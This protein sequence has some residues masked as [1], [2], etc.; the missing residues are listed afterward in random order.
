MKGSKSGRYTK[1]ESYVNGAAK[2]DLNFIKEK[3]II[4]LNSKK[5]KELLE[6]LENDSKFLQSLK[7]IDYSLLLGI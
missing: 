6:Q 1:E 2:K 5:R 4:F 3:K 7:L